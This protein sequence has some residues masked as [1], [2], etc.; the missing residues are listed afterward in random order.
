[1]C[2]KAVN[3]NFSSKFHYLDYFC[4]SNLP[5]GFIGVVYDPLGFVKLAVK[6]NNQWFQK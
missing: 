5:N 3:S 4:Y 1:M 2:S 6:A